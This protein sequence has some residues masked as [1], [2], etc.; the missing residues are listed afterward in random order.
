MT[1]ILAM[2]II[3]S[4]LGKYVFDGSTSGVEKV[5]L[6]LQS[7][8]VTITMKYGCCYF[9]KYLSIIFSLRCCNL[10]HCELGV[11]RGT[12]QTHTYVYI[13]FLLAKTNVLHYVLGKADCEFLS[14][15]CLSNRVPCWTDSCA[16]T[17]RNPLFGNHVFPICSS[18]SV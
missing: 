11:D 3:G 12:Q 15:H 17:S 2:D 16:D 18:D 6:L 13:C 9:P 10:K 1:G 7:A 8:G 4:S 14:S 5:H